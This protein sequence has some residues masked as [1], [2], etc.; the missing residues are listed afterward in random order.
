VANIG[1]IYT[2]S[3]TRQVAANYPSKRSSAGMSP[4]GFIYCYTYNA[5]APFMTSLSGLQ[6]FIRYDS[7]EEGDI[8][9]ETLNNG[10]QAWRI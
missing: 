4:S 5:S 6:E 10:V 8:L 9:V 2:F 1:P 3:F 7:Q